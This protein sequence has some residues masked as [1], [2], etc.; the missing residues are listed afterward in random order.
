MLVL[1]G[2]RRGDR[3]QFD[4]GELVLADHAAGVA[5]G[6][7][8][9]RA[10]TRRQRG[11]A[12]RQFLLVEDGLA[13]EVGERDFG[14]RDETEP[15]APQI[16]AGRS[17]QLALDRPELVVLEFRQLT[18]PEH[19][20]VAHEQ[21]RIDFGIAV[22][23]G[24]QIDHELPDR[25]LEPRQAL[26]QHD[27]ARAGQFCRRLEIHVAERVAEIVMRLRRKAVVAASHRRRDVARCR[28][29]RCRRAPRRAAG[30]GW[31]TV[32]GKLLVGRLRRSLELRHPRLELG[33]FGHQLAGARLILG[34][35]GIADLLRRRIASRL[36]LLGGKNG[37]AAALVDRQQRRRHRRKP[38]PLQTGVEGFGVVADRFD[39]VHGQ[40]FLR[41]GR[42]YRPRL[43]HRPP[44]LR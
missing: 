8:R 36:R 11:Q 42:A 23:V 12:H 29:R 35:L 39:V 34:L 30:S 25:A 14:G 40:L 6:R 31:R 10:K 13:D 26:L 4:L 2:L 1:A 27:E 43:L 3:D 44:R 21:R 37:R 9:F 38:A 28:A 19:H 24:V 5:T 15:L 17:Q 7:A 22:L 32:R 33:D 18:G 16:L 41:H 20:F